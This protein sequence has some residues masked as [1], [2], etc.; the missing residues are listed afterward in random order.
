MFQLIQYL[1]LYAFINE[2]AVFKRNERTALFEGQSA[3]LPAVFE[4]LDLGWQ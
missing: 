3:R 4:E 2:R 1:K